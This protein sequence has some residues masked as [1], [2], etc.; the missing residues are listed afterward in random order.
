MPA[1]TPLAGKP[2][3]DNAQGQILR[4]VVATTIGSTV[5][6]YD[7]FLYGFAATLVLGRLFFPSGDSSASTL[8]ALTTYAA[9]FAAR[10][11]GAI[12]VGRLGDRIGRRATLIASLLLIG[13]A[14]LLTGL[15]PAHDRIGIL[16]GILL[17][18]LRIA[19][20]IGMGGQWAT[21]ILLPVE[22]GQRDRR[23]FIG[24][25]PQ[26]GIPAGLALAY[27]SLQLFTRL[28]G[29]D[30]GWRIP[31]LLGFLLVAVAV[32]VR[33]G[34]SETPVFTGLLDERRIE[35]APVLTVAA[36]QWREVILTVLLRTGQ[37][38]PFLLFTAFAVTYATGTLKLPE[39]QVMGYVLIAAGLSLVT[40]PL[41]GYLSDLVG[42]R[43]LV[44]I[45][46][47]VMLVWAFPY[48][49]LLN[50]GVP[51]LMLAAIALSLPI[52][53]L[54]AGPQATLIVESFTGRLRST[55]ASLGYQLASLATDGPALLVA[56]A[57]LQ[58]FH[59]ST[60][61]VLYMGAMAVV[62]LASA[63]LLRDRSL[64]DMSVEYD[65]PAVAAPAAVAQRS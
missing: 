53:D 44:M 6:W 13:L 62:S 17:G 29:Q 43:R 55:G 39:A 59:G 61:L 41:S 12:L 33:L 26:L 65:E 51:V 20:G 50:T 1:S 8:M 36:R 23:G 28:L 15:V 47:A 63:F 14:A 49:T 48:W 22:W 16:G 64:Q 56:A 5:V 3:R 46:A 7:F 30:A 27:G 18:L 25:W 38:T 31:F 34:V 37:Q 11:L 21:S 54:Q 4:A 52:H 58:A 57:L 60:G 9:G 19:Q 2:A 10:P 35:D 42:R 45:G 32:Y 24:S 40:V